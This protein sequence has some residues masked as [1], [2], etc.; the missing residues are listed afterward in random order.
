MLSDNH[1]AQRHK[2]GEQEFWTVRDGKGGY[3]INDR[4]DL[5]RSITDITY[6][7]VQGAWLAVWRYLHH[8]VEY[9]E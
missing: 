2:I 8:K 7:T 5:P 4:I 3:V 6:G 1:I 9:A